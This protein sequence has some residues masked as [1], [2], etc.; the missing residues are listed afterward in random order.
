MSEMEQIFPS[1]R[2]TKPCCKLMK[3]YIK[4]HTHTH[5]HF[6]PNGKIY[7]CFT[8]NIGR[9]RKAPRGRKKQ[10][11]TRENHSSFWQRLF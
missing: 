9:Q 11:I 3:R 4:T 1:P 8:K 6:F 2:K 10:K 7:T 5:T